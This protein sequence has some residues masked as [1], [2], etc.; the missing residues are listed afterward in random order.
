MSSGKVRFAVLG[1]GGQNIHYA[2]TLFR[3]PRVDIVAVT[4]E[5]PDTVLAHLTRGIG[6]DFMF[7]F[8]LD[9]EHGVGQELGNLTGELD[10]II[11]FS[12]HFSMNCLNVQ[13]QWGARTQASSH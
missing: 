5:N 2:D 6:Q 10:S 9:S 1:M 13:G 3:S 8:E 11:F 7:V 4:D 12:H